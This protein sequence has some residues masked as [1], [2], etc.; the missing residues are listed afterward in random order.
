MKGYE[1]AHRTLLPRRT[2]TILRLDG[3]AF[4]TYLRDT[5]KPFDLDFVAD[6]AAVTA[7][8]CEEA[9]G[10]ALGYAQS[11]EIS[12]LLTD[13]ASPGT[14]PWFGGVVAKQ[15][16]VSASL[17]TAVLN[18]RRPGGRALFDARV[19]TVSDPVEVANYFVWRQRDAVRNSIS[20]AARAHFPHQRLDRV[21]SGAM[22]ELLRS[23]KGID[24]NDYPDSCKRGQLALR[25]TG[26]RPVE[27]VDGRTGETVRTTAPTSC[28]EVTAAPHFTTGPT[29]RLARVIPARPVLGAGF[30]G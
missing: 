19:F 22:R 12:L 11:D 2:Y 7:A 30:G 24:W 4:H 18:E 10:A 3:R 1:A 25:R 29:G 5:Q 23:E 28:W 6:M 16:S 13:F 26:E 8:L 15:L 20:T 14:E 17:A 9:G 21:S 27:Y